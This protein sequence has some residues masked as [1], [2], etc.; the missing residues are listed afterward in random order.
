MKIK[1]TKK[2]CF[3]TST[4]AEYGLLKR[5]I[6]LFLNNSFFTVSL[7]VTGT[8]L[9]EKYGMTINE[10]I[11]DEIP[12]DAQLP[13]L[14]NDTTES[15][16]VKTEANAL[17]AFSKY[18][19]MNRPDLLIVLGDR[20][21][22]LAVC[23]VAM[24]M[25]IPIAH[26]HGGETTEGAV[27]ECI[28][29]SITKMS[30]LHFVSTEKYK[31]R[32]IQ[33]GESPKRVYNVGALGVENILKEE[34]VEK[35]QLLQLL[36]M[37]MNLPYSVVT[38]H[39]VTLD[40]RQVEKQMKEIFSA[41][42]KNENMQYIITKAN[43]DVDGERINELLMQKAK[44]NSNIKVFDSLGLTMYLSA[45]KYARMVIG[46]SSSGIIEAPSFKV[47]TI[48]IGDRQKGRI[49]AASVINCEPKCSD[50]LTAMD[51]TTS[52]EFQEK[53]KGIKNPYE[54]VNTSITIMQT[55][56]EYLLEKKINLKK[57]FYDIGCEV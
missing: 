5:L 48:N 16:V 49:Q 47:P 3:F 6:R 22:T 34:L 12:I 53:M 18:F 50:I 29:H 1:D 54:G 31:R 33:L 13:I 28:R 55:V 42:E 36:G 2:V 23:E 30:Y 39:P 37:K 45:L 21:E 26:I 7:V 43:A 56:Q 9:S 10:I 20:Y 8:H 41:F 19:N 14:S 52:W 40:F 44:Q 25:K 17:L 38:Y 32:V 46:N 24:I 15:G 4:R 51:K 35:E 57:E 11:K 27:D